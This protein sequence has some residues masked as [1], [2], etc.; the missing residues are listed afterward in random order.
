MLFV[1]Q[2]RPDRSDFVRGYFL[3]ELSGSLKDFS[4]AWADLKS[5]V[6]ELE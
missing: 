1:F 4:N 6:N 5:L 3:G 2:D